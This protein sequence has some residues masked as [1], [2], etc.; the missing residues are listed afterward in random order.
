MPGCGCCALC[1]NSCKTR[2]VVGVCPRKLSPACRVE[3][4]ISLH[5]NCLPATGVDIQQRTYNCDVCEHALWYVRVVVL[6]TG[7]KEEAPRADDANL[8]LGCSREHLAR[9][10]S[11]LHCFLACTFRCT[12]AARRL[13]SVVKFYSQ[14]FNTP[15]PSYCEYSAQAGRN[16]THRGAIQPLERPALWRRATPPLC[17]GAPQ[18]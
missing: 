17:C 16:F 11:A 13:Q 7:A 15:R 5:D 6:K 3:T 14:K 8:R 4:K 10:K 12:H 18:K 2:R 9:L 1:S